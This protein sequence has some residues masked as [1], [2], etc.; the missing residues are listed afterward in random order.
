MLPTLWVGLSGA[1]FGGG[2][3]LV[4]PLLGNFRGRTDVDV[5][6]YWTLRNLGLGHTTMIR[7]RRAERSEAVAAR[8][9]AINTVRDEVAGALADARAERDRIA[10]AREELASAER[11][12][13]RDYQLIRQ[14]IDRPI[15][16]LDSLDQLRESRE[17]LIDAVVSYNQAQFRLFVALGSPPPLIEPD[18]PRRPI[19]RRRC[20]A[21]VVEDAP[22]P[23][24]VGL[25]EVCERARTD[26][27][28]RRP[29]A[30][31][32]PAL[33]ALTAAHAEAVDAA[34]GFERALGRLRASIAGPPGAGDPAAAL[35]GLDAL[36]EAHRRAVDAEVAFERRRRAVADAIAPRRPRPS[37]PSRGPDHEAEPTDRPSTPWRPGTPRAPRPRT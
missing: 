11:G 29:R 6:A 13:R 32:A 15:E 2:S 37:Q 23:P 7:R 28:D 34:A 35:T 10:I 17:E 14:A 31:P 24:P 26:H 8:S 36:A 21:P 20:L 4:P 18:V 25:D 16:V 3:N 30:S 19:P 9:L 12:F 22:P 33:D 5:R 1:A 27:P